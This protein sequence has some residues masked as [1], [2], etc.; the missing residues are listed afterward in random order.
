MHRRLGRVDRVAAGEEAALVEA[1]GTAR[2][3]EEEEGEEMIEEV[4]EVV[5]IEGAGTEGA[6]LRPIIGSRDLQ[7]KI[8]TQVFEHQ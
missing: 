3:E 2:K 7:N 5:G 6:L 4:V 8:I 1:L